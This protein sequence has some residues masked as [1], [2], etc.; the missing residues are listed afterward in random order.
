MIQSRLKLT[1]LFALVLITYGC[2]TGSVNNGNVKL[3]LCFPADEI[4]GT[5]I[6]GV[7]CAMP[8]DS[9]MLETSDYSDELVVTDLTEII[10][11]FDSL[12]MSNDNKNDLDKVVDMVDSEAEIRIVGHTCNVGDHPYNKRLSL[13]RANVVR[14]YLVSKGVMSAI[15]VEGKGATLP[16]ASNDTPEG[17]AQNRRVE[18]EIYQKGGE[19]K[20]RTFLS[21][22]LIYSH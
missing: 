3:P 1:G 17:R 14:D 20:R 6:E 21:P 10:F 5:Q 13:N 15:S 22:Y 4:G 12:Q 16:I 8:D 18:I 7:D 2:A 11:S 9:D 19:K